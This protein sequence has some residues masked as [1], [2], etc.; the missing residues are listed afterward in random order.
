MCVL[1]P[2]RTSHRGVYVRRISEVWH[3]R[4]YRGFCGVR[5]NFPRITKFGKKGEKSP[6][7]GTELL[8]SLILV[9]FLYVLGKRSH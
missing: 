8:C 9:R 1:L 5:I 4:P 6:P 2:Q 7:K 3:L